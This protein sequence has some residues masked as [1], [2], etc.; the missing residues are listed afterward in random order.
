MLRQSWIYATAP[1]GITSP[2]VYGILATR[3]EFPQW[4]VCNM[5][6][7]ASGYIQ[8]QDLYLPGGEASVDKHYGYVGNAKFFTQADILSVL[9]DGLCF[10]GEVWKSDVN[11]VS[12][13]KYALGPDEVGDGNYGAP[14]PPGLPLPMAQ[15]DASGALKGW[16]ASPSY[17]KRVAKDFDLSTDRASVLARLAPGGDLA[18]QS[19][20]GVF[21]YDRP[22]GYVHR[23]SPLTYITMYD[24]ATSHI[25]VPLREAEVKE[26]FNIATSPNCIGVYRTDTLIPGG[27]PNCDELQDPNFPSW[28]CKGGKCRTGEDAPATTDGYFLIVELEQIYWAA[29]AATGCVTM[30]TQANVLAQ[31]FYD[32]TS[33]GC[34]TSKWDPKEPDGSGLPKGDWCAATNSPATDTCHDAM[35]YHARQTFSAAKVRD[36][37]ATCSP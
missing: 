33:H 5:G 23:Y 10:I 29:L 11:D 2:I 17:Q 27:T 15:K 31:G 1:V 26:R 8:L 37:G 19:F 14:F 4:D 28:G 32:S 16:D 20:Q 18:K 6:G 22:A 9:K 34:K 36:G 3:S 24:N 25:T 35:R 12:H 21:Y 13:G 7:G 30:P